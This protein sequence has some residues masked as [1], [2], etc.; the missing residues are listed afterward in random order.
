M[1]NTVTYYKNRKELFLKKESSSFY[2]DSAV[3]SDSGQY[4]CIVFSI[5][6][7]HHSQTEKIEVQELFSPPVLKVTPSQ[8][9]EGAMVTLTCNTRLHPEKSDTELQF[10]FFRK[11]QSLKPG[12]SRSPELQIPT[13]W[14]QDSGYYWCEAQTVNHRVK[15]ESIPSKIRVQRVPVANIS[16]KTQPP[17]GQVFEGGKLALFCSVSEGTGNITFSWHRESTEISLA[18]KTHGSWSAELEILPVKESDAGKYYCRAD[19]G[20]GPV[21]TE[22]NITVRIP[23]SRPVL[24]LRVP[25]A[26]AIVGNVVEFHCAV[27]RGSPPIL[28]QFYHED[29]T[30]GNNWAS[31]KEEASFNLSLTANHSGMYFCEA[32]NGL[33]AQRSQVVI[34]NVTEPDDFRRDP[35]TA[36]LLGGLSSMLGFAIIALP[37]YCWYHKRAV[38][39]LYHLSSSS[40]RLQEFTYSRPP[41]AMEEPMYI[42]GEMSHSSPL[43]G[44]EE[45]QP[46][47]MNGGTENMG[48]VYSLLRNIQQTNDSANTGKT[49]LGTKESSV[50]YSEVKK[51]KHFEESEEKTN[52]K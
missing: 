3:F 24:T 50:I 14:S 46:V 27:Q 47:Y 13:I 26:Q 30:L 34:L 45:L 17:G 31:L 38:N 48:V 18:K 21:Q 16:L 33:E 28:Y 39:S 37:F 44:M 35:V 1:V 41:S 29:A 52:N 4:Y 10:C 15:K 19:N 49:F 22:V 25:G 43:T 5:F 12:W 20:H 32:S 36:R 8:P 7:P 11:G 2:I 51:K 6:G 40:P 23:V 42:N 9:I